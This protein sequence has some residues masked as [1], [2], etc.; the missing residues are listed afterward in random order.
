MKQGYGDRTNVGA[1]HE[2]KVTPEGTAAATRCDACE[3]LHLPARW[4]RC[5]GCGSKMLTPTC[6]ELSGVFESWTLPHTAEPEAGDWA[7]ALVTL[8]AGPMLTVRVKMTGCPPCIGGRVAGT[9]ERSDGAPER[10][11]FE[12]ESAPDAADRTL[13]EAA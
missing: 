5:L 11:W 6:V 1:S 8:D 3:R 12:V 9:A 4:H 13:M 2:L 10:F 7:L